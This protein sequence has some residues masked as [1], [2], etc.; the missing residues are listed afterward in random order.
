MECDE[1]SRRR[2]KDSVN[3]M[4]DKGILYRADFEKRLYNSEQLK[5]KRLVEGKQEKKQGKQENKQKK[6]GDDI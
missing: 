2:K 1:K 4:E 6:N 3:N 5:R